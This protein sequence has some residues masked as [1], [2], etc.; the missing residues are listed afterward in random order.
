MRRRSLTRRLAPA[1]YLALIHLRLVQGTPQARRGPARARSDARA[2]RTSHPGRGVCPGPARRRRGGRAPGVPRSRCGLR[3]RV[4]PRSRGPGA[5]LGRRSGRAGLGPRRSLRP[6][7][8]RQLPHRGPDPRGQ[9]RTVGQEQ[10]PVPRG[11]WGRRAPRRPLR[12]GRRR[13]GAHLRDLAHRRD[14][15]LG[16]PP[17]PRSGPHRIVSPGG[18]RI[19][20]RLRARSR[21][22]GVV[23]GWPRGA[24]DRHRARGDDGP[25]RGDLH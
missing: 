7:Q 15:L 1:V 10:R 18:G 24:R 9:D 19:R 25:A 11:S 2:P 22:R 3:P 17:Q 5:V 12:P 14:R 21:R 6:D 8:R 4:R 13:G 20:V 23:L 16:Q